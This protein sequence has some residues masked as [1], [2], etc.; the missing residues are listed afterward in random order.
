MKYN[1]SVILDHR[2]K[3][4]RLRYL[5][6]AQLGTFQRQLTIETRLNGPKEGPR[7]SGK[8]TQTTL[9]CLLRLTS[10]TYGRGTETELEPL[11]LLTKV[12][13]LLIVVN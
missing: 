10:I 9:P 1:D 4:M 3:K 11:Q 7:E 13:L 12:H 8:E 5:I 2:G 6:G